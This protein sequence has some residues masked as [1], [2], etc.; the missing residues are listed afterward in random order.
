MDRKSPN[1]LFQISQKLSKDTLDSTAI[2]CDHYDHVKGK[3]ERGEPV[4]VIRM[5]MNPS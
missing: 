2:I 1:N 3:V 4:Q 5:V